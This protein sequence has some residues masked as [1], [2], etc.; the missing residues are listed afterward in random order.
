[1]T[2]LLSP[3]DAQFQL[4]ENLA[5]AV[6]SAQNSAENI[7]TQNSSTPTIVLMSPAAASF[8]MFENVYDRGAQFQE[9]VRKL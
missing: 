1:M 5:E 8:D 7:K 4:V 2:Q 3:S 6:Q 9:I